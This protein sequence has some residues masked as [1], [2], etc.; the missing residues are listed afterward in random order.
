MLVVKRILI[1]VVLFSALSFAQV[2]AEKPFF[3]MSA[4]Y[5]YGGIVSRAPDG[6]KTVQVKQLNNESFTSSVQITVPG[7]TLVERVDFGLNAQLLWRADSNAFALTGSDEGAN[8]QYSTDVFLLDG[9]QLRQISITALVQRAFGHPVVCEV[10]ELPN[11]VAVRWLLPSGNLL[12]AAQ[13][14]DHSVCDSAGTFRSYEVD[15][16]K[17]RIVRSYGQ[18]ETKRLFGKS[19]GDWLS[20][21]RDECI[22]NPKSCE[23][24]FHHQTNASSE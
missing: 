15:V 6:A 9:A 23:V 24:P 2:P 18:I 7:R 14:I 3:S 4:V 8:G 12:V 1:S 13:I 17:K 21:A 19:L 16:Q 11:V 10:P 5:V 20:S 22:A